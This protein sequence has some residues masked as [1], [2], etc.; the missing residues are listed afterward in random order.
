MVLAKI[1]SAMDG[2]FQRCAASEAVRRASDGRHVGA[3]CS[4]LLVCAIAIYHT[5]MGAASSP[6]VASE[7]A[8]MRQGAG[9]WTADHAASAPQVK[10]LAV[11]RSLLAERFAWTKD[12]YAAP[13]R[14]AWCGADMLPAQGPPWEVQHF[15]SASGKTF[16]APDTDGRYAKDKWEGP[17]EDPFGFRQKARIA[18]EK[19]AQTNQAFDERH[20]SIT[21][22]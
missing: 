14:E 6:T 3:A 21:A 15:D 1:Y 17:T 8:T 22:P 16:S 9:S 19:Q 7:R 5:G 20:Q 11:K 12:F 4:L 2:G 13:C 18:L 10:G